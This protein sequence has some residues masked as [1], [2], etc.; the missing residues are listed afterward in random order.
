[1]FQALESPVTPPVIER[2]GE[3]Q[4]AINGLLTQVADGELTSQ[5]ALDQAKEILD[6]LIK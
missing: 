6:G 3:M 4:D 5:E 2:Q 1:M